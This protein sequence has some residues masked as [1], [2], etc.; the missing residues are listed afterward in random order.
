MHAAL[1]AMAPPRGPGV[2]G[3]CGLG[4][5][6]SNQPVPFCRPC[7]IL[8]ISGHVRGLV[9]GSN[10]AWRVAFVAGL[11]AG[12]FALRGLLPTAFELLP[13]AYT[14]QRATLAGLLVGLGTSRGSG[15][16]SGHGICGI[17]R[18]SLRS[19]AA[20]LSFMGAGA[21]T[22]KAAETAAVF[23]LP[24]GIAPLAAGASW[25]STATFA[26]VLL[27][28]SAAMWLALTLVAKQ[29]TAPSRVPSAA[30]LESELKQASALEETMLTAAPPAAAPDAQKLAALSSA[31]DVFIGF[32]FALGLG[33]S[34]MLKP[35][36]VVGGCCLRAGQG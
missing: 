9:Q 1:G 34:G 26:V 2:A 36:K 8:G 28:V 11:L 30:A 31:A 23:A 15:C 33:A 20:T 17:G 32:L 6:G 24:R 22:A 10:E 27:A 14:L 21:V 29:L 16:T 19:F 35:S 4:R 3:A 7:R 5:Q 25:S 18:L 13:A 12:G